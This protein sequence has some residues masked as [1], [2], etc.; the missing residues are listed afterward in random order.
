MRRPWGLDA[1]ASAGQCVQV[2][3]P[4]FEWEEPGGDMPAP[5][6][7]HGFVA[8]PNSSM[9]V[10]ERE[11]ANFQGQKIDA[12]PT[13]FQQLSWNSGRCTASCPAIC[14]LRCVRRAKDPAQW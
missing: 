12:D 8:A 5:L 13:S 4:Q 2:L 6:R 7:R 11:Q 14:F 9:N 3:V 1:Q 10:D